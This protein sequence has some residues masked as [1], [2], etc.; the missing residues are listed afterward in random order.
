MRYQRN[1]TPEERRRGGL[2]THELHPEVCKQ[3]GKQNLAR[4][5]ADSTVQ[6]KRAER[7]IYVE[8]A[9]REQLRLEGWTIIALRHICDSVGIK[10]G[11]MCL[12]EFKR[13]ENAPLTDN[14]KLAKTSFGDNYK[15]VYYP[16]RR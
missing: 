13:D 8:Q 9:T 2:K 7:R 15:V 3:N 12:L 14:Q 4:Y 6:R 11:R 16:R 10:D 5:Y 1:F